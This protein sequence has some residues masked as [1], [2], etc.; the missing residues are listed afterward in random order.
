MSKH[1]RI[2]EGRV[3]HS[4]AEDVT[5]IEKYTKSMTFQRTYLPPLLEGLIDP[6]WENVRITIKVEELS[7]DNL[8]NIK[9]KWYH[10]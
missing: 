10:E 8:P 7:Q 3:G 6:E 2:I 5:Y 4:F 1:E 9:T